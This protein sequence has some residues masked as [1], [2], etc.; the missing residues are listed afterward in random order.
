[1][2]AALWRR[3]DQP[4]HD[5]CR[6]SQVKEGWRLEGTAVFLDEQSPAKLTYTVMCDGGWQSQSGRVSGWIGPRTVDFEIWRTTAG[7]WMLN[8]R[9]VPELEHCLDLDYG[10]TPATNALVLRRLALSPGQTADAPAAWFDPAEG[11]LILLPQHYERRSESTYGYESPTAGYAAELEIH[12][13]GF[14][15]RYPGLW[16]M[17][18]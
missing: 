4:G 17:E 14:A 13:N 7:V 12:P 15:R 11:T 2:N 18:E 10:F 6:L 3:L 16:D 8:G 5:A 9:P 1:M